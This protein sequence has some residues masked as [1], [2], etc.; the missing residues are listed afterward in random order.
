MPEASKEIL[1]IWVHHTIF[2]SL[3]SS[4]FGR[5]LPG[6]RRMRAGEDE[7]VAGYLLPPYYFLASHGLAGK[8]GKGRW[9]RGGPRLARG[10]R[11]DRRLYGGWH[12][13]LSAFFCIVLHLSASWPARR[14]GDRLTR[15]HKVEKV[16][17]TRIQGIPEFRGPRCCF[18][19]RPGFRPAGLWPFFGR[20]RPGYCNSIL[21][22]VKGGK[23][24]ARRKGACHGVAEGV[25]GK[26]A[27]HGVAGKGCA[28]IFWQFASRG[29]GLLIRIPIDS[30]A[31]GRQRRRGLAPPCCSAVPVPGVVPNRGDR[32]LRGEKHAATEPVP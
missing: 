8:P 22:R 16:K 5:V 10:V 18:P 19:F 26:A 1:K 3:S 24:Q 15:R 31:L 7:L 29:A 6:E 25:A 27:C 20:F 13:H 4:L 17:K 30:R 11:R 23:L 32:H 21:G 28:Y 14:G 12:A 9:P 2:L